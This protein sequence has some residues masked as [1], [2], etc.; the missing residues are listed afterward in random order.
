MKNRLRLLLLFFVFISA[1]CGNDEACK[2]IVCQNN[3]EC[4][5]GYCY[6]PTGYTGDKCQYITCNQLNCPANAT[7][8]PLG[9]WG[10]G[11]CKCNVGYEGANCETESRSKFLGN[12]IGETNCYL[13]GDNTEHWTISAV[14]N[15]NATTFYLGCA[16]M[17]NQVVFAQ[18]LD[19]TSFTIGSQFAAC[20][21][22]RFIAINNDKGIAKRDSDGIIRFSILIQDFFPP[23]TC[24][25][26]LTPE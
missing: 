26:V 5:H 1:A 19:S 16:N 20:F 23:D 3:G 8:L 4:K 24:D 22:N 13:G 10:A 2:D 21:D 15:E 17:P 14:A 18:L 7:C 12:Y 11:V 6:C 25:V 9:T